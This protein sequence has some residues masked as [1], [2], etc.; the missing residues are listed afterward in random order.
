MRSK[1]THSP[2]SILGIAM[3]CIAHWTISAASAQTVLRVDDDAAPG[4]DG[5][6]WVAAFNSLQDAL[7]AAAATPEPRDVELWV[8]CGTYAPDQGAGVTPGDR[9]AT[10]NLVNGVSLFGGFAGVELNVADRSGVFDLTILTGDLAADDAGDLLNRADN[11]INV[12]ST[13]E[14]GS[15]TEVNGF[16]IVNGQADGLGPPEQIGGGLIVSDTTII[17]SNCTFENCVAEAAGGGVHVVNGS[18]QI[19]NCTFR[20]NEVIQGDGAALELVNSVGIIDSTNFADNAQRLWPAA[21]V[22]SASSSSTFVSCSFIGNETGLTCDELPGSAEVFNCFFS[23]HA[24]RGILFDDVPAEVSSC[25]FVDSPVGFFDSTEGDFSNSILRGS[26]PAGFPSLTVQSLGS[27]TAATVQYCNVEGNWP[28]TGNFDANPLYV[29]ASGADGTI[30]TEDDNLRLTLAS[31]CIDAGGNSLAP[32]DSLD[33]DG[34][35]DTSEP[36]SQDFDGNQRFFDHFETPD[37]GAGIPP[38]IDIGAFEFA[39]PTVRFATRKKTGDTDDPRSVFPIDLDQDG[40][41]DVLSAARLSGVAWH[42]ND[43]SNPPSFVKHTILA[44]ATGHRSVYAADLDGDLDIDVISASEFD[45]TVRWHENVGGAPPSFVEHVITSTANAA[46]AVFACDIDGDMDMDIVSAS[47]DDDTVAWYENIGGSPPT[48]TERIL[49]TTADAALSVH[50]ADVDGDGDTDV[51]SASFFDNSVAWFDNQGGAVPTFFERAL[52]VTFASPRSVLATDLD[53]DLDLDVVVTFQGLGVLAWYEND[54]SVPTP[55][56]LQRLITSSA[57]VGWQAAAADV[58]GDGFVDILV[59]AHDNDLIAWYENDGGS[60]P[61]F[62]ERIVTT[63]LNGPFSI[64]AADMDNDGDVDIVSAA[65]DG[66]TLAWHEQVGDVKNTTGGESHPTLAQAV[67]AASSGDVLLVEPGHFLLEPQI[68]FGTKALTLQSSGGVEL[69]QG[70]LFQLADMSTIEA[71]PLQKFVIEGELQAKAGATAMVSGSSFSLDKDGRIDVRTNA[72]LSVDAPSATLRGELLFETGSTL[73]FTGDVDMQLLPVFGAQVVGSLNGPPETVRTGDLDG[74]GDTDVVAVRENELAWY[75]NTGDHTNF[76]KHTQASALRAEDCGIADLDGDGDLDIAAAN[77]GGN[78]GSLVVFMNN[79]ASPPGFLETEFTVQNITAQRGGVSVDAVDFDQDGDTDV[80]IVFGRVSGADGPIIWF[81]NDGASNPLFE[82][83]PITALN[84]QDV[85][86]VAVVDFD[87]DSDLDVI[88][89]RRDQNLIALHENLN[90]GFS[91]STLAS[92]ATSVTSIVAADFDGDG[93][94]DLATVE[95]TAIAWYENDGAGSLTKRTVSNIAAVDLLALDVDEDGDIDLVSAQNQ[96]DFRWHDNEGGFPIRFTDR[97]ISTSLPSM[98]AISG[99]DIDGDGVTDLLTGSS[100]DNMI[101]WHRNRPGALLMDQPGARLEAAGDLRLTRS[102]LNVTGTAVVMTG[103]SL[104]VSDTRGI[105]SGNGVVEGNV[106]NAGVVTPDTTSALMITGN[107]VQ[108]DA[109]SPGAPSG[110]LLI[111]IG[112]LMPGIDHDVL[113]VAGSAELGGGLIVRLQSSFTPLIGNVFQVVSAG[114]PITSQFDIA[115]FPGLPD[116]RFMRAAVDN[117]GMRGAGGAINVVVDALQ[118]DDVEFGPPQGTSLPGVPTAIAVGD[119]DGQSGDDIVVTI[120]G[121]TTLDPGSV[122]S[123]LNQDVAPDGTWNGFAASVQLPV[124]AFPVD[125]IVAELDSVVDGM[126]SPLGPDLAILNRTDES[127]SIY[128]NDG[129]GGFTAHLSI[130]S[131]AGDPR[132]MV[133][134]DFDE[135]G[136][137]DLLISGFQFGTGD[138]ALISLRNVSDGSGAV[139]FETPEN[140][141]IDVD[142]PG[143]IDPADIDNVKDTDADVLVAD[144]AGGKVV[145]V[146]NTSTPG[147]ISFGTTV[148]LAVDVNPVKVRAQDFNGDGLLDIVTA[149]KSSGTISVLLHDG[150]A[151]ISYVDSVS[152]G[153][154]EDARSI[155]A[156]DL[157]LDGPGG[158]GDADI[159]VVVNGPGGGAV[160]RLRN[161]TVGNQPSFADE[162]FVGMTDGTLFVDT[163][164]VNQDGRPDLVTVEAGAGALRGSGGGTLFILLSLPPCPADL[165]NEDRM[166]N[167]AD[168]ANLLGLWGTLEPLAD[169][170][171]DGSVGAFDLALLLGSWGACP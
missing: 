9:G 34:D 80:V 51:L 159:A 167:S 23:G 171:H 16:R 144:P 42:E 94:V 109:T 147:N 148:N 55:G 108:F 45:D 15:M 121:A 93:D 129:M 77:G 46:R 137:I 35:G 112:G 104:I 120:P 127:V 60:P 62:A 5:S 76:F 63:Q 161:D 136:K 95:Q 3:L 113:D 124:G 98:S 4:G 69:I 8:A 18:L 111:D 53:G 96:S 139:T 146:E 89:V 50:A 12:L 48:F 7:G 14:A 153:V 75:E 66:D 91:E 141:L 106:V 61:A 132:A 32:P 27:P 170:D 162:G 118:S 114:Q 140:K 38:I 6:S 166:V 150:G 155:A 70:S 10:F 134:E 122:V 115:F 117:G 152:F 26:S 165:S 123:L 90:P 2:V 24:S 22:L 67:S 41:V 79:G 36:L 149:N 131:V 30:G 105:L 100:G 160:R 20:R 25:T 119:V 103:G 33:L 73:S 99:G 59:A 21:A 49:T 85:V 97:V 101:R 54:G 138:P 142:E 78:Q 65:G 116:R 168:L 143:D 102:D 135:D 31:P 58:N 71:D 86:D 47:V 163:A 154:G 72:L 64:Q 81:E 84:E 128:T 1:T 68:D 158:N 125:V 133:A 13:V 169:L 11:S 130:L 126:D 164:D 40:D 29:N 28:G 92:G 39:G 151:G 43:G 107:Y 110:D 57:D 157:D 87:S 44:S 83:Q 74:D 52:P 82:D 56:F 37:S 19:S 156:V 145:A 88:S 17:V